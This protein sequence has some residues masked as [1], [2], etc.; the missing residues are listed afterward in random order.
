[1]NKIILTILCLSS[2]LLMWCSSDITQKQE[3]KWI[4]F[5]SDCK[6]NVFELCDVLVEKPQLDFERNK[7]QMVLFNDCIKENEHF[8]LPIK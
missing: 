1:M 3:C 5:R 8:F 4:E 7:E 6:N 2:V